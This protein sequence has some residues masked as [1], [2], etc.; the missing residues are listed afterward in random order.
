M[1]V[2]CTILALFA[3][4][5]FAY[6]QDQALID[7]LEGE[8]QNEL[9]DSARIKVLFK[10]EDLEYKTHPEKSLEYN[11]EALRISEAIQYSEGI[12]SSYVNIGIIYRA[13]GNFPLALSYYTKALEIWDKMSTSADGEQ[14]KKARFG[15][16]AVNTNL[17]GVYQLKGEYPIALKHFFN[18]AKI[19]EELVADDPNNLRYQ[20]AQLRGMNN[21][22]IVYG[23]QS[24]YDQSLIYFSKSMQLAE[25][26]LDQT[27]EIVYGWEIARLNSNI[28]MLHEHMGND[29]ISLKYLLK[30]LSFNK[31]VNNREGMAHAYINAGVSFQKLGNLDTA[32]SYQEM[33]LAIGQELNGQ[34]IISACFNNLASIHEELGKHVQAIG[35]RE[36]ALKIAKE[37]GRP[38]GVGRAYEGLMIIYET[39]GDFE[40][41]LKYHKLHSQ[42]KDSLFN[43][44][45]S[46]E[47]GKLEAKHEFETAEAERKRLEEAE[48][49]QREAE[50]SRRDNLQYSVILIAILVL[51][52]GVLA[53]GF[54]NVSERMAEGLIFFSF[55]ILFEFLL[56]LADPYIDNWSGGAP[57][58]KLL[59]NAGIAALIFPAHAF[60]E[61]RLKK[62][63]VK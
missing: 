37:S 54:V 12:A 14:R 34:N 61:S 7:S 3:F 58:I 10:L 16:A 24:D 49:K 56:V 21:V 55:L 42:V 44:T 39:L 52:G 41:A 15:Q 11:Q 35:Y 50:K 31:K 51:F 32:L 30:S 40:Q 5:C 63:L 13:Q 8:L 60:F 29:S 36:E 62:R 25:F 23:A 53:L 33:A 20:R 27:N 45:K 26:L 48:A 4:T 43:E 1:K 18:A 17:G 2:V 9:T 22:G 57:G 19:H 46:K 47:I 38:E 59:F 6:T 28:G